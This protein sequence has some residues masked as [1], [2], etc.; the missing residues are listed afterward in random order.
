MSPK[1]FQ[2][3]VRCLGVLRFLR[4]ICV[5]SNL[6]GW[7]SCKPSDQSPSQGY[8]LSLPSF[9]ILTE[10]NLRYILTLYRY[11]ETVIYEIRFNVHRMRHDLHKPAINLPHTPVCVRVT[12]PYN[13]VCRH[14]ATG[15]LWCTRWATACP[16][17]RSSSPSSSC[18]TAGGPTIN[19]EIVFPHLTYQH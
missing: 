7:S 8:S 9:K 16:W 6:G 17:P 3:N 14:K 18:C 1:C 19:D 13:C 10:I 11:L 15:W 12:C 4:T 5:D 2:I